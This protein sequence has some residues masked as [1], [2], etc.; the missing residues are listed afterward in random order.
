MPFAYL[1]G[2]ANQLVV[3]Q[4]RK[5]RAA[6]EINKCRLVLGCA[7]LLGGSLT[8]SDVLLNCQLTRA[9]ARKTLEQ[10]A[11]DGHCQVEMAASGELLYEFPSY[12]PGGRNKIEMQ[13]HGPPTDEIA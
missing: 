6:E 9:D 11:M 1:F 5:R 7:K 4:L 2:K 13:S 8:A 10:L 3:W 12:T